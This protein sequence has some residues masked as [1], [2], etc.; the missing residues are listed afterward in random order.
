MLKDQAEKKQKTAAKKAFTAAKKQ[1]RVYRKKLVSSLKAS[2]KVIKKK[3]LARI[4]RLPQKDRAAARQK[5]KDQLKQRLQ[6][7][8]KKL[9]TKIQT[10]GQLREIMRG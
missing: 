2:N 6:N 9:P 7:I 10:P 4:R 1:Y 5:L 3:E 8:T